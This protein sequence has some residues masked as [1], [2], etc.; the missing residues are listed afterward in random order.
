M[1]LVKYIKLSLMDLTAGFIGPVIILVAFGVNTHVVSPSFASP[2]ELSTSNVENIGSNSYDGFISPLTG[3]QPEV[4]AA[5]TYIDSIYR[6]N[7][8][9]SDLMLKESLPKSP[10]KMAPEGDGIKSSEEGS[11]DNKNSHENEGQVT[12]DEKDAD[13]V[14]TDESGQPDESE[15]QIIIIEGGKKVAEY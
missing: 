2:Y 8:D 9:Q 5:S 15:N 12:E 13:D 3:R 10:Q 6:D 7:E 11:D 4:K 14:E 1:A